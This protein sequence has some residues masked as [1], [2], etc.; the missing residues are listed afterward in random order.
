VVDV[1]NVSR[2]EGLTVSLHADMNAF[3]WRD[4]R[5]QLRINDERLHACLWS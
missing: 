1:I 3:P 2:G 5:R 4:E